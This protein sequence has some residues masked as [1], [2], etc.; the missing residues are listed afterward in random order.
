MYVGPL[1]AV[2][3]LFPAD[4][5]SAAVVCRELDLVRGHGALRLIDFVVIRKD[6]MGTLT[7]MAEETSSEADGAECRAALRRLAGLE[8]IMGTGSSARTVSSDDSAFG[9]SCADVRAV[10]RGIPPGTAVALAL[11]EHTWASALAAAIRHAGGHLLA[12]GILARDAAMAVGAEARAIAEAD[13]ALALAG[14]IEAGAVLDTLAFGTGGESAVTEMM[15]TRAAHGP[16]L[17]TSAAAAEALRTLTVAGLIDDTELESALV[18][19]V[20]AGLIEVNQ[21]ESA[22]QAEILARAALA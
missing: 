13:T 4:Q 11:F 2:L 7:T 17:R 8:T 9:L 5:T 3:A 15:G 19:L 20:D 21:F 6:E 14:A 18:A 1:H 10:V 16:E 12:H 22:L